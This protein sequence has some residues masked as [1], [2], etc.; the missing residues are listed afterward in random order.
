MTMVFCSFFFCDVAF[1][2]KCTRCDGSG[3]VACKPCNG[4]GGTCKSCG[5]SG[6]ISRQRSC[7][8]PNANI[9]ASGNEIRKLGYDPN[10][11][12]YVCS[13][14]KLPIKI[15][16]DRKYEYH[17]CWSCNGSGKSNICPYCDGRGK[18]LCTK[19]DGSGKE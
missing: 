15:H 5:G 8:D 17:K 14:C 3:V 1:A 6:E 2:Q 9:I 16:N 18:N 7:S 11:D 4:R 12:G 10:K 19:C 13:S